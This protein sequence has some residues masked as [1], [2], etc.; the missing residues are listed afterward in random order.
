MDR[1]NRPI[2][3]RMN[4]PVSF[5]YKMLLCLRGGGGGFLRI[6]EKYISLN[7][8]NYKGGYIRLYEEA[9]YKKPSSVLLFMENMKYIVHVQY[10]YII[11]RF[12]QQDAFNFLSFE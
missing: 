5:Q 4:R 7:V 10:T 6:S 2:M 8:M 1:V 9:T 3:G 11:F 12:L